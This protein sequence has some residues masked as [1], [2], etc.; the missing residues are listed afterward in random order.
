MKRSLAMIQDWLVARLAAYL[1]LEPSSI[2]IHAA[3]ASYG[4]PSVDAVGLSGDLEDWLERE[5]SP[6]LAYD[7]P[8]I[9]LLA[10]YLVGD[11]ATHP[12]ET[13]ELARPAGPAE[14]IAIIGMACRFPGGASNLEA[15]W[16]LLQRG[17]E[18]IT[19]VPAGRWR[20]EDYYDPDPN[21]AGKMYT[22]SGGFITDLDRFDAAFFGISPREAR[23]MDP[24][25]RLLLEVG[26]EALEQ[27]GLAVD[28]LAG[29]QTGVFVG[30]MTNQEYSLLQV[31]QGQDF[32][33]D[34]YFGLGGAAS[35]AAGRLPYLFD[36]HGPTLS[37]DTACSSSLVS[38]HLACQSLRAGECSLALAGGVNAIVLPEN[39]VNACKMGML[40]PDGRCKPFDAAANGFVLGEGCGMVVLKRLSAA[41]ADGDPILAIIRGSA[42]NQDGRSNG[43]TAPNQL[44]QQAVIR[45]AL[46]QADIQPGQVSYVEAHGSGTA[47]GDPIEVQALV[48]VLGQERASEQ[49]LYIGAVKSNIGHLAGAAGIAGLIKT[50]L[51]LCRQQIPPH[52]H[53]REPN[54][55]IPWQS[56]PIA[57]PTSLTSLPVQDGPYFA[58]VSSFGWSGTNAHII[59]EAAPAPAVGSIEQPSSRSRQLLLLSARTAATLEQATTNLLSHLKQHP[60]ANLADLAYTTQVGRSA[61]QQRRVLDCQTLDEAVE[62]LERRDP[63]HLRTGSAPSEP[64]PVAFLFPGLGEQ[65]PGMTRQLYQQQAVFREAVDR[66]CSY[67]ESQFGL[68]VRAALYPQDVAGLRSNR[69]SQNGN[70]HSNGHHQNGAGIPEVDVRALFGRAGHN[71]NG[72]DALNGDT[73]S[74]ALSAA[75]LKRTEMAQPALF[76][77][78]YALAQLLLAWG[79]RPSAML[80]Y[81]LGEYVAACLSGVFSLEDALTLVTCRAQ[82]IEALSPGAMLAVA[83]S[84]QAVQPYLDEQVCLAAVNGPTTCVLAGPA[85]AIERLEEQMNRQS[86]AHRRVETTHAFHSTML[87]SLREPLTAL[88][89]TVSLHPPRIPYI[90]NV[91]GT[92]ITDEQA[93]DPAYWSQHMCRTVRFSSGVEQLLLH[94]ESFLLEV[95]AGQSLSSFVKQHPACTRERM[96]L[97]LPTLPSPYDQQTE[98]AFLLMTIGKLW[99]AGSAIDWAAFSAREQRQRVSLPT[100]PFERQRYWIENTREKRPPVAQSKKAAIADWF[101]QPVWEQIAPLDVV[102]RGD[103]VAVSP[104]LV[105]LDETGIGEQ[106]AARLERAGVVV[107]RAR[108]A[109]RFARQDEHYFT[110][111]P[112]EPADYLKLLRALSEAELLPRSILHLWSLTAPKEMVTGSE[113]FHVVQERGFYSLL[114]LARALGTQV[115]AEPVKV[116]VVSNNMQAVT[117]QESLQPEKATLLGACTV[118]S[119]EYPDIHCRGIDL[120]LPEP[121]SDGEQYI[122]NALFA[123][124]VLSPAEESLLHVA[125]RDGARWRQSYAPLHLDEIGAATYLRQ[126]GVYLITGGLGEI[127][128]VLADHL[129]RSV[130]A[131]L[132]LTSRSGLPPRDEWP[133]WLEHHEAESRLSCVIQQMQ[134]LE[135]LGAEVLVVQADVADAAQM[136]TVIEQAVAQFG[137][138]HG[139][140]HAAGITTAS[141]FRPVASIGRQECEQH[142]QPKVY[143]LYALEQALANRDLDFCL[144][145][146][147]ISSILGGLSFAGYAAAN[148]FMDAYAHWHNQT[149]STRW[150]SVNWESWQIRPE[151]EQGGGLS[152]LGRTIADY[153]MNAQEGLEAFHRI[154]ANRQI[155]R[156][157]VS[158]GDLQARIQQW[159]RLQAVTGSSQVEQVTI[160]EAGAER[161]QGTLVPVMASGEMERVIAG[162]WRQALGVD[163]VGLYE[164]FFD[165]G[166][167]SLI[168]LQVLAQL[169]QVFHVQLPAVALFEAPT[170]SALVKYLQPAMTPTAEEQPPRGDL[171]ARRREE[172]RVG[173]RPCTA[174]QDIAIIGLSGRFPGAPTLE[175]F[176]QNLRNGVESIS[177]FSDAELLSAGVDSALLRD[178][179][180]VRARPILADVEHFDAAFFGYSPREAELL[181]PQHRLFL[182][183]CWEALEDAAYDPSSYEGLIG[184]FGGANISTYLLGL[185][186]HS[187]ALDG[188]DDYSIVISND[189]DSLT[190]SVS[191]KLNLRGPS[192]AVQTFCS[193]SLVAAHLAC[194]SLRQGECDVA[195]AGGVSVRVPDVGGHLYQQG[196]MESPDGHVRTFDAQAKGSMFG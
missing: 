120:V 42:V 8:S 112:H 35:V 104:N 98:Q 21:A 31:Q 158:T 80:G 140:I 153:A 147:S 99:L 181:D 163:Q 185:T 41:L 121:G 86:I 192:Y 176:W 118:I 38:V 141:A 22:R 61:F 33:D 66:C 109:D 36:F 4:L 92:W 55:H 133:T 195:L 114:F 142:F 194:Q 180:Y 85:L 13:G 12:A 157:I 25:H 143:G 159:V 20:S 127:G 117:G 100:Y 10:R 67:L 152:K 156:M 34:P 96:S 136:R 49:P 91:T 129:A 11:T 71:G 78:E 103:R 108:A 19:E 90:S 125:Y 196:G 56:S 40:S 172:A 81:S 166:G 137:A 146:S 70:H 39:M 128:L 32:V 52:P 2:D 107:I 26:W 47:L 16:D 105:F 58:G 65:S 144:L 132:V 161:A 110:L 168:G 83:L 170:I 95:G 88:V 44:A 174:Q 124:C 138:L 122:I 101:Y 162:I 60:A 87:E 45:Q 173:A 188:V 171:L 75:R 9:A 3:F 89:R 23:R 164:N 6:T 187:H 57:V 191:Y 148:C 169:K 165:L 64:R 63:A 131:R 68:D 182:E 29:S 37:V 69:N 51:V 119:Q 123:E 14:P 106:I 116:L 134:A 18:A 15:F 111:R 74:D 5:L 151:Q 72:Y 59:L 167:N 77:I 184:V 17:G 43:L 46:A 115:I 50:V 155:T 97:A 84:E 7:Y 79:I 135:S 30:M 150:I 145:F 154:L 1:D 193:T 149:A 54:P 93:T 102:S 179:N 126:R 28:R 113:G 183:C 94:S 177:F 24:Q 178:P 139:V 186:A 53:L 27:A 73:S 175:Q 48:A 190:T 160:R 76:V 189:K 130:Q 82:L 62:A